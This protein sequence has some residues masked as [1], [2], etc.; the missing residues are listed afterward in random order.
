[1][2][3]NQ[4]Y[5]I[6]ESHKFFCRMFGRIDR[7]K[8]LQFTWNAVGLLVLFFDDCGE[9]ILVFANLAIL[10]ISLY[11]WNATAVSGLIF[12]FSFTRVRRCLIDLGVGINASIAG[13]R[14]QVTVNFGVDIRE[15]N[16]LLGLFL[17]DFRV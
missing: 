11:V 13:A 8:L 3:E 7:E 10:S 4:M 15:I 17:V 9:I 16:I 6:N 2:R 14:L 1:M 12:S 5:D